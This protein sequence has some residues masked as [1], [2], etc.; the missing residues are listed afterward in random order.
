MKGALKIPVIAIS[1]VILGMVSTAIAQTGTDKKG[2]GISSYSLQ[3]A[4][5]TIGRMEGMDNQQAS[6]GQVTFNCTSDMQ[7]P[8][9]DWMKG[10]INGSTSKKECSVLEAGYDGNVK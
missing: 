6:S 9:F 10:A 1:S 5:G 7:S 8:F 4:G 3:L 2:G